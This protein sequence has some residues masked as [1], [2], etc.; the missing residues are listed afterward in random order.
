M[1]EQKLVL[2]EWWDAWADSEPISLQNVATSHKPMLVRTLGWVLYENE[3][4]IQIAN[5]SYEDN[6]RGRSFIPRAMLKSVIPY[7]LTKP[8]VKK[9][10]TTPKGKQDKV[11]RV[12]VPLAGPQE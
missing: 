2:V 6:F 3:E 9:V 4:G 7:Q 12:E 8:R 10:S 11:S 1:T 5:E